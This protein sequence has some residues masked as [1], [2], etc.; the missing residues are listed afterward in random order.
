[1]LYFWA[2]WGWERWVVELPWKWR[3]DHW[4]KWCIIFSVG[5]YRSVFTV[6]GDLVMLPSGNDSDPHR[7]WA[8]ETVKPHH[9]PTKQKKKKK[10]SLQRCSFVLQCPPP[11]T[12][13]RKG[14]VGGRKKKNSSSHSCQPRCTPGN[15]WRPLHTTDPV[16]CC[17]NHLPNVQSISISMLCP[18]FSLVFRFGTHPLC[19]QNHYLFFFFFFIQFFYK[20]N[21]I[22]NMGSIYVPPCLTKETWLDSIRKTCSLPAHLFLLFTQFIFS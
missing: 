19:C 11:F 16:L 14:G 17:V 8:T 6:Q 12:F 18:E 5:V 1:M 10:I 2:F 22:K 3:A 15:L 4:C 7:P 20:L 13:Q 9:T 21:N